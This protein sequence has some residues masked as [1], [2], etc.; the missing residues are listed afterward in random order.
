MEFAEAMLTRTHDF[1]L[2]ESLVQSFADFAADQRELTERWRL[3]IKFEILLERSNGSTTDDAVDFLRG[4]YL[5]IRDQYKNLHAEELCRIYADALAAV[6]DSRSSY[7]S[8][9]ELALFRTGLIRNYTIG[10]GLEKRHGDYIV[11]NVSP[12]FSPHDEPNEFVG[13]ALIALR[14][15]DGNTFHLTES[16][17]PK[18]SWLISSPAG[19]LEADTDVILELYHPVTHQRVSRTW[20]RIQSR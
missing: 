18:T 11:T 6:F 5:G 2:D 3:R 4:R 14:R 8:E 16:L 13:W 17:R 12:R 9:S 1:N 10:L 15:A 19:K 20:P 7:L